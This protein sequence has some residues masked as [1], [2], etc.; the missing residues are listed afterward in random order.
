[1]TRALLLSALTTLAGVWGVFTLARLA[2][3]ALGTVARAFARVASRPHARALAA[4][5]TT[6]TTAPTRRET[7]T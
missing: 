7:A 6:P 4:V 5:N 3:R 1:M 2:G